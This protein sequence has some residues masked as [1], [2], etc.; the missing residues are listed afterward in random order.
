M[1]ELSQ[2]I[3]DYQYTGRTTSRGKNGRSTSVDPNR[4][5]RIL[6]PDDLVSLERGR[7]YRRCPVRWIM[8]GDRSLDLLRVRADH[9]RH[10]F[11]E[12]RACRFARWRS[13]TE[14]TEER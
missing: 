11:D 4:K 2:F 1:S 10:G 14:S 5:E 12:W 7:G 3:G 8:G 13:G 9:S 6:E